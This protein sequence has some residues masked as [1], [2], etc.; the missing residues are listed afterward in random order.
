MSNA[1]FVSRVFTYD[2]ADLV[3]P[4]RD[5]YVVFHKNKN[6]FG[7]R[8]ESFDQVIATKNQHPVGNEITPEQAADLITVFYWTEIFN[9]I[10]HGIFTG[11]ATLYALESAALLVKNTEIP[12]EDPKAMS[13]VWNG[14][15]NARVTNRV[16]TYMDLQG[17]VTSIMTTG[18]SADRSNNKLLSPDWRYYRIT[19]S[20][21]SQST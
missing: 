9:L 14:M 19:Q 17:R 10:D 18:L 3:Y 15:V 8:Y 5:E 13:S 21:W 6:S 1:R 12:Q 7:N 4:V 20:G 16:K 2:N 11:P